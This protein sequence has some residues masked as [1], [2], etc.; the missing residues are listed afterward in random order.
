MSIPITWDGKIPA[1]ITEK[2]KELGTE[3][4]KS[5][6]KFDPKIERDWDE[7]ID[8]WATESDMPLIIRKSS[9]ARGS[10]VVH[11]S[12]R[13][14]I[15][16][17]NSP[18]QW[19]CYLALN[20]EVKSVSEIKQALLDDKVPISFAIKKEDKSKIIY[21]QTLS[22]YSINKLGWKLCHKDRVGIGNNEDPKTMNIDDVIDRFKNL[23]KPSNFFL[24][25]LELGGLG[26]L[27]EFI[28]EIF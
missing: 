20:G 7:V 28:K 27:D 13:R 23:M 5:R 22:K 19:V 11:S 15:I 24:I 14:I 3:W 6:P 4:N 16:S 12:G 1:N 26:E 17:D 8:K 21:R 9:G 10:E 2:I 18:A 25:P